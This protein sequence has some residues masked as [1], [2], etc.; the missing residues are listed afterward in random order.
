MSTHI[1]SV[2]FTLDRNSS[3]TDE[4]Y[5][6]RLYELL[7]KASCHQQEYDF[8]CYSFRHEA[9][10]QALLALSAAEQLHGLDFI[11]Q[12]LAVIT[13]HQLDTAYASLQSIIVLI[14]A[15][16]EQNDLTRL[17]PLTEVCGFQPNE[18]LSTNVIRHILQEVGD[19][20]DVCPYNTGGDEARNVLTSLFDYIR[21]LHEIVGN[22]LRQQRV[23]IYFHHP[24]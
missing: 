16:L 13:D 24:A 22:C 10:I 18:E 21:S 11:G 15:A 4:L 19:L 6:G 5:G 3:Y 8:R 23:L 9:H 14:E 17:G 20:N 7:D 1:P 12:E 2:V